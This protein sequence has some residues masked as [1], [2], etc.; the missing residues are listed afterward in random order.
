MKVVRTAFVTGLAV[1]AVAGCGRSHSDGASAKGS[2]VSAADRV[3]ATHLKMVMDWMTQPR[4]GDLWQQQSA[5]DRGIYEITSN[6]IA[7]LQSLGQAPDPHASAF[8][9]YVGTLKARA[10]LY[11]LMRIA[12]D[13]HEGVVALRFQRRIYEIDALGDR[14]AH[15]YGLQICGSGAPDFAKALSAAGWDPR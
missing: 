1:L 5:W 4:G 13:R 7:R 6:T 9:G 8:D 11:M 3:C 12:N 14:R 2:F 15:R 10:S